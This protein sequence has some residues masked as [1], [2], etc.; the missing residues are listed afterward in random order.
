[1]ANRRIYLPAAAALVAAMAAGVVAQD[2]KPK[3]EA[4]AKLLCE[5]ARGKHGKAALE[6]YNQAIQ[7]DPNCIEAY[8]GRGGE[9]RHD[10]PALALADFSRADA[11]KDEFQPAAS[12]LRIV[13]LLDAYLDR[14]AAWDEAERLKRKSQKGAWSFVGGGVQELLAGHPDRAEE[15][16][17]KA[18]QNDDS[19]PLTVRFKALAQY[20]YGNALARDTAAR[21]A[22]EDPDDP[23]SA[24][25]LALTANADDA[26]AAARE[27]DRILSEKPKLAWAHVAKA[28]VCV[29][30][31][32]WDDALAACRAADA[33]APGGPET[34]Y[35]RGLA[36]EGSGKFA[37]AEAALCFAVAWDANF[38]DALLK[39]GDLRVKIR[40]WAGALRDFEGWQRFATTPQA[41]K[42]LSDKIDAAKIGKEREE[43][44]I[45]SFNGYCGR[46]RVY[47]EEEDWDRAAK[48]LDAAKALEEKNERWKNL[49]VLLYAKKKDYPKM[50]EKVQEIID[51]GVEGIFP[52]FNPAGDGNKVYLPLRKEA[53]FLDG[54]RKLTI[55]APR[56]QYFK[57]QAFYEQGMTIIGEKKSGFEPLLRESAAEYRKLCDTWKDW[58]EVS[59]SY[60]NESCCWSLCNDVDKA[61]EAME[62]AIDSGYGK[63][64]GEIAHME[65]NDTDLANMRKD[66]RWEALLKKIKAKWEK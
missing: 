5:Q 38:P 6:M 30:Q 8:I 49:W 10:E 31:S 41:Q 37:E 53:L 57:A 44:I 34:A 22:K 18:G 2:A 32:K 21:A 12:W 35:L 40:D 54:L 66:A 14:S 42:M 3:P 52:F 9:R 45:V 13:T 1:M 7:I 47:I 61:F 59:G 50:W 16:F 17:D 28:K 26:A 33:A 48:D 19:I 20:E 58:A 55:K 64:N 39:R 4:E 11:I 63:D 46:A 23:G 62:R 65:K 29:K 25:T 43:G 56:D 24:A 60:Y 51:S 36:L 27:L 15:Y